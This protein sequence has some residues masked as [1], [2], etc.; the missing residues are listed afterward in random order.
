MVVVAPTDSKAKVRAL[1]TVQQWS[2]P[3]RDYQF[4][5][6]KAVCINDTVQWHG[7]H[8]HLTPSATEK[9]FDFTYRYVP[10]AL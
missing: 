5:I 2:S 1:K 8:I 4:D 6:E 3:H 9:L 10:I 7:Y